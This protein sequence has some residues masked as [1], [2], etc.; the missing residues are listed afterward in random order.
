MYVYAYIWKNIS[1]II[2]YYYKNSNVVS[3]IIIH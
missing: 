3:F 1:I 2:F